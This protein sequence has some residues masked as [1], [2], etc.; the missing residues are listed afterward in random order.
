MM[1]ETYLRKSG[2]WKTRARAGRTGTASTP[3]K[4]RYAT[5]LKHTVKYGGVWVEIID[6]KRYRVTYEGQ[7]ET[8]AV[9]FK[10][11]TATLDRLTARDRHAF[12]EMYRHFKQRAAAGT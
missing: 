11:L 6:H 7:G 12:D 4:N 10:Q 5:Y 8:R 3:G 1:V 9:T 2:F